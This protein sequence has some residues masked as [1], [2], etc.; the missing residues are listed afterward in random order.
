M[1]LCDRRQDTGGI[2]QHKECSNTVVCDAKVGPSILRK[3]IQVERQKGELGKTDDNLVEDLRQPEHLVTSKYN[4][5]PD[6][7]LL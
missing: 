1:A 2:V 5:H 3:D 4:F 6:Y 7:H